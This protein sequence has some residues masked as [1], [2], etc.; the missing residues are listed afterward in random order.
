[1]NP[2]SK[3]FWRTGWLKSDSTKFIVAGTA[4]VIVG[5]VISA[6]SWSW[7]GKPHSAT[8]TNSETIRNVGFLIGGVLAILFGIW[9]AMVAERQAT[10]SQGQ[11]DIGQR[12]LLNE[13]Y[14]QGAAMLGSETLAVRLGGIYALQRLAAEDPE[15]YHL[16]IMGLLCSFV[17][18]PTPD[19]DLDK[20]WYLEGEE[21]PRL[22]RD[23]VQA[24]ISAVG[25]RGFE[26][27]NFEIESGF[28]LDLSGANLSGSNLRMC[29]FDRAN[30]TGANLSKADLGV[31]SLQR[32]D[33]TRANLFG[34]DL[35]GADF[36]KSICRQANIVGVIANDANFTGADLE[37]V[38]LC[39][40]ELANACLSSVM[41]RGA[42][43]RRANL[44]GADVS[45][46]VLGNGGR[47]DVFYIDGHECIGAMPAFT[48]LTQQQL[49]QATAAPDR[50]PEIEFG[51]TDAE[52]NVQLTWQGHSFPQTVVD[53]QS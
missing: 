38:N 2:S 5:I 16:Q 30:L 4:V 32:T 13:R 43:L 8:A 26:S 6:I 40:A 21:M 36:Q 19:A 12:G 39:N 47:R 29:L 34:A 15:D 22:I 44:A 51:T 7:L 35:T 33:L 42:D 53:E 49:D 31:T 24:A 46:A 18:K 9:R 25:K 20:I 52:T 37:G 48:S 3:N 23:D 14:Q 1:M 17:R 45:G 27:F 28:M 11:T 50:P 10:A 41:I